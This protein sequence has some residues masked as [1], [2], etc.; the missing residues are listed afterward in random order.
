MVFL[1]PGSCLAVAWLVATPKKECVH[2]QPL[3]FPSV[4]SLC[5]CFVGILLRLPA[6][7]MVLPAFASRAAFFMGVSSGRG[8]SRVWL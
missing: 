4:C 1:G 2:S 3:A 8:A 7:H 5:V 6:L